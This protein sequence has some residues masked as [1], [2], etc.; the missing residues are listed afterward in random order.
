MLLVVPRFDPQVLFLPLFRELCVLLPAATLVI[1]M[2]GPLGVALPPPARVP[3]AGGGSLTISVQSALYHTL[4]LPV[5]DLAVAPNA[6]LAVA[7]YEERWPETLRHL[8]EHR[9]PF[10]FTDYSEQSVEKG[11]ARASVEMGLA[12]VEKGLAAGKTVAPVA[13]EPAGPD[14]RAVSLNPFR[15]P[16]REPLVRGGAVGFPTVSNGFLASL[17]TPPGAFDDVG[18]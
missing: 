17:H 3:S 13:S 16:L 18:L 11:L 14:E 1:E 9:I 6:G 5:P 8:R 10:V 7:G 15:M 2:I 12:A 4:Q